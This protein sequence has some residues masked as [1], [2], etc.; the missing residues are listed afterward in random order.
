[1]AKFRKKPIVIEAVQY[2]REGPLAKGVC[3][4]AEGLPAHVHTIHD[5]QVAVV[6]D[7]DWI[8]AEP[9]GEHYYPCKPDIFDATYEPALIGSRNDPAGS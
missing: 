6:T 7:G 5:R 8:I 9:D 4:C 1:M 3:Y 2:R